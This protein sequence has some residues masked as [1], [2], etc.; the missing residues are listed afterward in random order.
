MRKPISHGARLAFALIVL[1]GLE[2]GDA[3]SQTRQDSGLPFADILVGNQFI[4]QGNEPAWILTF[5]ESKLLLVTELGLLHQTWILPLTT[6]SV[7]GQRFHSKDKSATLTVNRLICRD[8]MTGMPY[9]AEVTFSAEGKS[10]KGCGGNP[11]ALLMGKTWRIIA[12]NDQALQDFTSIWLTVKPSG[13]VNG[14]TGCFRFR[15]TLVAHGEGIR[16][17]PMNTTWPS[18]MPARMHQAYQ[19]ITKLSN[20]RRFDLDENGILSLFG[21]GQSILKALPLPTGG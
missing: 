18:C 12:M 4:A 21:D 1:C 2:N 7:G 5:S 15:T 11:L 19:F 10:W 13:D 16:F 14:S 17:K 20:V 9:P 8:T 6:T 3:K